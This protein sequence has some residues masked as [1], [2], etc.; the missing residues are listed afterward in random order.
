MSKHGDAR[1]IERRRNHV[2][3]LQDGTD[4]KK[5]RILPLANK[6]WPTCLIIAPSSVVGNWEREF[7]VVSHSYLSFG[8]DSN[9][10][11]WG[12]FEVGLYVGP[13]S[14]REPVLND[15]K[16]GRLDVGQYYLTS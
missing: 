9:P 10:S 16:M 3:H 11:Q 4:W 14:E 1:D 2:S 7:Q 8:E 13:R 6:T 15:F 12:Y 5:R